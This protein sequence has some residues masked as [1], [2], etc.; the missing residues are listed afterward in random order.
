MQVIYHIIV[1]C[2]NKMFFF[3][4]YR[5]PS[6]MNSNSVKFRVVINVLSISKSTNLKSS[7]P[8]KSNIGASS[9]EISKKPF[10]S[11]LRLS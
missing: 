7:K 1:S 11:G 9:F 4:I 6:P 5:P 3:I 2:G 10:Q 8:V